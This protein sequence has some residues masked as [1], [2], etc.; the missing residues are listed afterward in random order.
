MERRWRLLIILLLSYN[1]YFRIY[2]FYLNFHFP[3]IFNNP[4]N[5]I[6]LFH[7][8]LIMCLL[9]QS[10]N[11]SN[12]F[13]SLTSVIQWWINVVLFVVL[14]YK[15]N[16]FNVKYLQ[17]SLLKVFINISLSNTFLIFANPKSYHLSIY[18]KIF[19]NLPKL[20]SW[21]LLQIQIY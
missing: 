5:I 10:T 2:L 21:F 9:N 3:N 15:I 18:P 11:S 4:I 1:F 19:E 13:K 20:L 12:K 7:F 8:F 16:K 14:S 17:T 6:W